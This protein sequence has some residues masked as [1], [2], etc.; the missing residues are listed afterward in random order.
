MA[1]IKSTLEPSDKPTR[2]QIR[3]VEEAA[4]HPIVFDEDSPELTDEQ[5][6]EF[7]RVAEL[8]AEE[9]KKQNVTIRL[10]VGSI[11]KAKALGKGYTGILSRIIEGTLDDPETLKRYL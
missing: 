7:R 10:S 11:R 8:R 9:R 2:K 1:V 5:M 3:M 6:A 4:M